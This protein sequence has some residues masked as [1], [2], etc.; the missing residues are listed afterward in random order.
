MLWHS[1]WYIRYDRGQ[2]KSPKPSTASPLM[3]EF[4]LKDIRLCIVL[5]DIRFKT[6]ISQE[7]KTESNPD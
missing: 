6:E 3:H 2:C 5:L 4:P 1:A 7:N